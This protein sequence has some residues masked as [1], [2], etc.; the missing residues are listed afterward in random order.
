[1]VD[2]D[3]KWA[4]TILSVIPGIQLLALLCIIT[5]ANKAIIKDTS[6][7]STARLLRPT[8]D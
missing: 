6:V 3:W 5:W 8:V 7:L 1:M 2:I 4:A